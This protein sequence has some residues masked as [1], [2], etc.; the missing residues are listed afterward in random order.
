M[1]SFILGVAVAP[2]GPP[3]E[4][5]LTLTQVARC[6]RPSAARLISHRTGTRHCGDVVLTFPKPF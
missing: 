3:L 2:P 4:E 5:P 1:A 6:S